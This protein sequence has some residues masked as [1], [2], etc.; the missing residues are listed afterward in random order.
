MS[1]CA[2]GEIIPADGRVIEGLNG[3]NES[4]LTG[5]SR[6]VAKVVG[7]SVTGGSLNAESPL[8][9]VVV[10]GEETRLSAIVRLMERAATRSRKIV[11]NS[12][13]YCQLLCACVA[14]GSVL[15]AIAWYFYDPTRAL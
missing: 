2:P 12:R 5:S 1:L 11:I 9:V 13:S 14:V 10:V 15:V 3:T 4:L 6:P 7:D 8:V